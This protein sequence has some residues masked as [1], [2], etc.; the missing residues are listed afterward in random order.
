MRLASVRFLHELQ[1]VTDSEWVKDIADSDDVELYM[2]S[3][4]ID[5]LQIFHL[6]KPVRVIPAC[7]CTGGVPFVE[8]DE[9]V[10]PPIP[11]GLLAVRAL[12][13]LAGAPSPAAALSPAKTEEVT[14]TA[15]KEEEEPKKIKEE[16]PRAPEP[17]KRKK[18]R[19]VKKKR[20]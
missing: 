14:L 9:P 19:R 18:E 12:S 13:I 1:T 6:G 20:G 4:P 11:P 5:C 8:P 2:R 10:S 17:P 15:A 3:T 7:H 16:E